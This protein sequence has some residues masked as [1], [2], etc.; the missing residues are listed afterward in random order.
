VYHLR[1]PIYILS[2]AGGNVT[3]SVGPDGVV[4][5]DTG[6]AED[7]DKLL[8]AIRQLQTQLA[9]SGVAPIGYGAESISS[10][11]R[12]RT[13]AAPPAPIRVIVNTSGDRDHAGGNA[14]V[15]AAGRKMTGGNVAAAVV[16]SAQGA[17]IYAHENVARRMQ[18]R[19]K[20]AEAVPIDAVPTITFRS[21]Y[22]KV[23]P[24]FN[25]EGVQIY[26]QPGAHSDGD[27]FVFFRYSDVIAA[28]DLFSTV[29]YPMIDLERGGTIQGEIA[30][31]NALLDVA[32]PEFRLEGGTYVI[33]GHG[34][35][36]D[37]A[38]VTY[39]RDMVTI[40]RDRVQDMIQKG[41]TLEQVQAARP[42][43]DYDPR[44]DKPEYPAAKFVEAVYRSLKNDTARPATESRV[45]R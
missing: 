10:L 9:T 26:G 8:A 6:R 24:F 18:S 41:M 42:T 5:V 13:T 17:E 44:Y 45:G 33:P 3:A 4:L 21:E 20:G 30:G 38:D 40:I 36:S 43:A 32:F 39:Y 31:L 1:G 34:R 25:G 22:Y 19:E 27:S 29:T 14:K 16:D 23:Q 11:E 28:G 12:L 37:A 35:I 15:A 2:G 7:A